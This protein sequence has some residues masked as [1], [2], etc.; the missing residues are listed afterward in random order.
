MSALNSAWQTGILSTGNLDSQKIVNWYL[1][2][3]DRT[4]YPGL[5]VDLFEQGKRCFNYI[6]I[7]LI[8]NNKKNID[9]TADIITTI[10]GRLKGFYQT[11]SK[12]DQSYETVLI[13][14]ILQT[15]KLVEIYKVDNPTLTFEPKLERKELEEYF[16]KTVA[17]FEP[18]IFYD[19]LKIN[20]FLLIR[21]NY[22]PTEFLC[23]L[24]LV[25]NKQ[26]LEALDKEYQLLDDNKSITS[27]FNYQCL[28]EFHYINLFTH[29]ID[30][31]T[32]NIDMLKLVDA[33][34]NNWFNIY[35][36]RLLNKDGLFVPENFFVTFNNY[37]REA[38]QGDG[39][40]DNSKVDRINRVYYYYLFLNNLK[41]TRSP[42]KAHYD[43]CSDFLDKYDSS[44]PNIVDFRVAYYDSNGISDLV[45]A[46][47]DPGE[48]GNAFKFILNTNIKTK[49]ENGI[50]IRSIY[51]RE[52]FDFLNSLNIKGINLNR[53]FWITLD[54]RLEEQ[55]ENIG[56]YFQ[57]A[58]KVQNIS[59][60]FNNV[61][62]KL[63]VSGNDV[64]ALMQEEL[65]RYKQICDPLREKS[66]V[67]PVDTD[68]DKEI[69][70]FTEHEYV[71][72]AKNG[73]FLM[74]RFDDFATKQTATSKNTYE[75]IDYENDNSQKLFESD[76]RSIK[77]AK[78]FIANTKNTRIKEFRISNYNSQID[79]KYPMTLDTYSK[80]SF[81][82]VKSKIERALE[83]NTIKINFVEIT[84]KYEDT[85][86]SPVI[87]NI[88][89]I[90]M[91]DVLGSFKVMDFISRVI[92]MP[93]F[94]YIGIFHSATPEKIKFPDAMLRNDD[95]QLRLKLIDI[96]FKKLINVTKPKYN[97]LLRL[98]TANF[99]VKKALLE[100]KLAEILSR[101]NKSERAE[102]ATKVA[103]LKATQEKLFAEEKKAITD[104]S[105]SIFELDKLL[106]DTKLQLDIYSV[107][108]D[109]IKAVQREIAKRSSKNK[110]DILD[111][112]KEVALLEGEIAKMS[113]DPVLIKD[114]P[115]KNA[116]L[117]EKRQEILILET[118][119]D[120]IYTQAQ[121]LSDELFEWIN[122]KSS[123]LINKYKIA[124]HEL[125]KLDI[126]R[127]TPDADKPAKLKVEQDAI[128]DI[129]PILDTETTGLQDI[130]AKS[131]SLEVDTSGNLVFSSKYKTEIARLDTAV[132]V[133][134]GEH[135]AL[136]LLAKKP[137]A[138]YIQ[139]DA[140]ADKKKELDETIKERSKYKA[141]E[142]IIQMYGNI[143]GLKKTELDAKTAKDNLEQNK[144]DKDFADALA[145]FKIS[146]IQS[147]TDPNSV[148]E[149]N[150]LRL[151]KDFISNQD[152]GVKSQ[153]ISLNDRR[154]ATAIAEIVRLNNE[155]VVLKNLRDRDLEKEDAKLQ[156]VQEANR[157]LIHVCSF[158]D[159]LL[160]TLLGGS[161]A[162]WFSGLV[163]PFA[164]FWPKLKMF[165]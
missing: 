100:A 11:M 24:K 14:L 154:R 51:F 102:S 79:V 137:N 153:I 107:M 39:E 70:Y 132:Q 74:S 13:D 149:L 10:L 3:N 36:Y 95:T 131:T 141:K 85:S 68:F 123:M 108:T 161:S 164:L 59:E 7:T 50:N 124:A 104:I 86:K 57:I 138:H 66:D 159:T 26:N 93:N 25:L 109:T 110:S 22:S 158:N 47:S 116:A 129:E 148:E 121:L 52:D 55:N 78:V 46:I 115:I 155:L 118:P 27:R 29:M 117:D 2:S 152:L 54:K 17:H 146:A 35:P 91:F 97:N 42:P 21:P 122:I 136:D 111:K 16:P 130:M 160:K 31:S 128:K 30:S 4:K 151:V 80:E 87:K 140:A 38:Y 60:F 127:D 9:E 77:L 73:I 126:E 156:E 44:K 144:R 37:I 101:N 41:L 48:N 135:T 62:L 82:D 90:L 125:N 15:Y 114:L 63:G 147:K 92:N 53:K 45:K 28:I 157:W 33:T 145:D 89:T 18:E 134:T 162:G 99:G 113:Q 34:L 150:I 12:E 106:Y 61:V 49:I 81:D 143:W 119:I 58:Q 71:N 20:E 8:D 83:I 142:E 23:R 76:L 19:V 5:F 56:N 75:F 67:K 32:K 96:E 98:D 105:D 112:R 72:L 94:S 133:L 120:D 43:S 1:Q 40:D 139:I 64:I 165:R 65:E 103:I 88:N 84:F 6:N 69:T 163:N